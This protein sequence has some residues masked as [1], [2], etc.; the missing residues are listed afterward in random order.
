[1]E[2]FNTELRLSSQEI[3]RMSRINE[4]SRQELWNGSN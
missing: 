3:R 2:H 4:T 1:M